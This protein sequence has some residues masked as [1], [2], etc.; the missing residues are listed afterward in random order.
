MRRLFI[1][2]IL[3][4]IFG[5]TCPVGAAV[6]YTP[7][8]GPEGA[9]FN[10]S[11][12]GMIGDGIGYGTV[13]WAGSSAVLYKTTDNGVT[14]N[15]VGTLATGNVSENGHL[16]FYFG[17]DEIWY[18]TMIK[19]SMYAYSSGKLGVSRDEGAT[20]INFNDQIDSMMAAAS[21]PRDCFARAPG[22]PGCFVTTGR[23]GNTWGLSA[24]GGAT[25]TWGQNQYFFGRFKAGIDQVYMAGK[26]EMTTPFY[27]LNRYDPA[28]GGFVNFDAAVP[29]DLYL[30]TWHVLNGAMAN[31]LTLTDIETETFT[32]A[33][34][35]VASVDGGATFTTYFS[36]EEG[37][38]LLDGLAV[39]Q[40]VV[41]VAGQVASGGEVHL[42]IRMT[43]DGGM[44]WSVLVDEVTT[45]TASF[46][47]DRTGTVYAVRTQAGAMGAPGGSTGFWR[48]S[49]D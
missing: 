6:T 48:L 39:S 28:I 34:Y 9:A 44:S 10:L 5:L 23:M 42:Q 7:F 22:L 18:S 45:D 4:V 35:V 33:T 20:W 41:F 49:M 37:F 25:W 16:E 31:V 36:G 14:W 30:G 27:N 46:I 15:Q 2:L 26:T 11:N 40:G 38:T 1:F 8:I 13:N 24:D 47:F 19:S 3:S 17:A 29:A 21:S 12:V 32:P 43:F